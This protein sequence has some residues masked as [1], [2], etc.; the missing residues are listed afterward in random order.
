MELRIEPITFPE[1]IEFNFDELKQEITDKVTIYNNLVYTEE[2]V[3]EAKTDRAALNKFVKALSDERIKIKKQCLQ[4]YEAFEK[5]INELSAIVNEPIALIDKQIKEFD[6]KK[7]QD[8]MDEIKNFW[9][10]CDVPEGLVLEKIFSDKWLNASTSMKSIQD[11]ID[12]A[13]EKFKTD[14]ESLSNLPEYSFEAQQVYISTLD[15]GKALNEAHRLSEMAKKKAEY[16]EAMRRIAEE[17]KA[18][19]EMARHMTPPVVPETIQNAEPNTDVIEPVK[20]WIS[21]K[22]LLSTEDATALRQFFNDRNIEFEA[23]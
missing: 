16:E 22:A 10:S 2:Q 1:V 19:E 8:K 6:E 21:F 17:Q 12:K 9:N 18:K 5:R 3:K 7:K 14:M 23:I 4:P 13:I 15:V 11:D 20:Q